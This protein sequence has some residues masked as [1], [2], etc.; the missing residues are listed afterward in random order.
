MEKRSKKQISASGA[1]PYAAILLPCSDTYNGEK[2]NTPFVVKKDPFIER[3]HKAKFKK[4]PSY[5]KL[6][7]GEI[8]QINLAPH[9]F[10]YSQA[11]KRYPG[12]MPIPYE[13][14]ADG[15][16]NTDKKVFEITFEAR[17]QIFGGASAGS[18]FIV[19]APGKYLQEITREWTYAAAPGS[20]I[21]DSW[22]IDHFEN[23]RYHLLVYGP[24]GFLPRV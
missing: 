19:Y 23:N 17:N 21:K 22:L 5:K 16:L 15:K 24:N 2:V 18:P 1:V 20:S 8:K 9:S 11:G 3:I 13:L 7:P 14:Y 6:T 10:L 4:V 12:L